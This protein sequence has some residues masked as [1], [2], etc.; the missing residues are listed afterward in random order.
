MSGTA[1]RR[2]GRL[3]PDLPAPPPLIAPYPEGLESVEP[4]E[5]GQ[6]DVLFFNRNCFRQLSLLRHSPIV[7]SLF[8]QDM[9]RVIILMS[10][11]LTA[12]SATV[13]ATMRIERNQ[14]LRGSASGK[15]GRDAVISV[16]TIEGLSCAGKMFVPVTETTTEGTIQCSDKRK[17][18]FIA[19]GKADSWTG[20]GKLNDGSKFLI[21]LGTN[22]TSLGY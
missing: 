12:C 18:N 2:G 15:V 3:I 1:S 22:R 19:N 6:L 13:P 5:I 17:G 9:K 8:G 20:E 11:V 21:L 10:I 16:K 7:V 14:I 4:M